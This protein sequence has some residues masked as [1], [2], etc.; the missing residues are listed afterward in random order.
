MLHNFLLTLNK[1]YTGS[2]ENI[3]NRLNDHLNSRST[4]TKLQVLIIVHFET[5]DSRSLAVKKRFEIKKKKKQKIYR[6][7]FNI[8]SDSIQ[9]SRKLEG[10]R[11]ELIFSLQNKTVNFNCVYGFIVLFN[12]KEMDIEP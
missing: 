2:W 9:V 11:S 10:D 7:S 5:F 4:Y 6:V 12:K 8:K 3:E 1:Y